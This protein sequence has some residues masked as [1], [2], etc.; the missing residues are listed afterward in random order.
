MLHPVDGRV[1]TPEVTSGCLHSALNSLYPNGVV[2]CWKAFLFLLQLLRMAATNLQENC[3][4][5]IADIHVI[6][7]IRKSLEEVCPTVS[8][9]GR[10]ILINLY[11]RL[12]PC[13]ILLS[14]LKSM[15]KMTV[16]SGNTGR[17]M[18][19][20]WSQMFSVTGHIRTCRSFSFFFFHRG[21]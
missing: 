18:V 19:E 15:S 5:A 4:E 17:S 20:R 1:T 6:N 2:E 3:G 10:L 7:A 9:S 8:S 16:L 14:R 12:D 11:Y 13:W 21:S